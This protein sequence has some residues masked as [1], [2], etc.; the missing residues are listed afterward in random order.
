[1]K[2]LGLILGEAH[3]HFLLGRDTRN[4]ALFLYHSTLCINN[5]HKWNPTI[6]WQ[7]MGLRLLGTT[8]HKIGR[9]QHTLQVMDEPPIVVYAI[10]GE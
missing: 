4:H 6:I 7:Y 5:F 9:K 2:V 3:D 8:W 1:M 10:P